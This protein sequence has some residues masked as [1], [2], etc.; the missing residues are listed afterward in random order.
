MTL[1]KGLLGRFNTIR[2]RLFLLLAVV[3]VPA[4]LAQVF[5]Y[6]NRY[7]L[8]RVEVLQANMEV[9][10]GTSTAFEQ[11]V[12]DVFNQ[13]LAMGLAI[14]TGFLSPE[15]IHT[16]L[17]QSA[18]EHQSV[19]NFAWV[20][21]Q[22]RIE[23]SSF[24]GDEGIDLSSNPLFLEMRGGGAQHVSDLFLMPGSGMPV[25]TVSRSFRDGDGDLM[26]VMVAVIDPDLLHTALAFE[27]E[28]GGAVGMLDRNARLVFRH[29]ALLGLTW[30]QRDLRALPFIQDAL[31]GREYF[32]ERARGVEGVSRV[33]AFTPIYT[34]GW[35]VGASRPETEVVASIRT[36][37]LR[38]VGLFLIVI[39]LSIPLAAIVAYSISRPVRSLRERAHLSTLEEKEAFKGVGGPT[40]IQDLASALQQMT[41]ELSES[42][43]RFRT[44]FNG[45]AEAIYVHDFQGR[46]LV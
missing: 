6:K 19:L 21:S 1:S 45:T 10:R 39:L 41:K 27:R 43:K 11:F 16:I 18:D 23:Y 29:P 44:V 37:L 5:I 17:V 32:V 14:T 7:A 9:A 3:L 25:F 40:E 4:L 15:H 12:D 13:Q 20:D 8:R 46:F 31:K 35:V 30:K 2:G 36:L 33:F 38:D 22:G 28:G 42:E 24:R 26:G 34:I